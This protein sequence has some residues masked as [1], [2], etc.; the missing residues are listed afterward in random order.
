M[1]PVKDEGKEAYQTLL[2]LGFVDTPYKGGR[3]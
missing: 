3:R 2:E 1:T